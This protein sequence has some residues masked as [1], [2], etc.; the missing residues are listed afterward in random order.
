[1]SDNPKR[2]GLLAALFTVCGLV[3]LGGGA[4]LVWFLSPRPSN[5]V[6]QAGQGPLPELRQMPVGGPRVGRAFVMPQPDKEG[7]AWTLTDLMERLYDKGLDRS[8]FTYDTA[9]PD[10]DATAITVNVVKAEGSDLGRTRVARIDRYEQV[11]AARQAAGA[12]PQVL[13]WG[14]FVIEIEEGANPQA[15]KQ[16]RAVVVDAINP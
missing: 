5:P 11:E 2:V 13:S 4:A 8:K 3:I 14:K 12:S 10:R 15:V 9:V 1:M 7:A 6:V 16:F